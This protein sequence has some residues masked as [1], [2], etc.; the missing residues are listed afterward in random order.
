MIT[1]RATLRPMTTNSGDVARLAANYSTSADAYAELWSPV[2][3]PV[4]RRLLEALLWDRA[5]HVL[6]IG[7]GTGA[8]V[9]DIASLVPGAPVIG[10][11][12]ALGMLALARR[13]G[14]RLAAMDAMHLGFR[15][16]VF[17][18]AVMAFILFHVSDPSAA[19][20][21]VK[22]V[23]RSRGSLGLA[24]WGD[25]PATPATQ[26]WNRE[27]DACAAQDPSPQ[28]DHGDLMNTP[29]KLADLLRAA[30]V[31]PERVWV[32]SVEYQW[33]VARFIGLRTRF[34][35]TKR[36]LE[37]LEPRIREAFLERIADRMSGLDAK[38]FLC[39]GAAICAVAARP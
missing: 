34:G 19:L 5:N 11:D 12:C 9:S 28:P 16:G 27:L 22:R 6:D 23:L 26:V 7:T 33:D 8:L 29:G 10:I 1:T 32:E 30:G 4:G 24:I 37:T 15:A 35:A 17:D 14:V 20:A 36:R 38:D 21:E 2:I 39:R 3:R 25:E 13:D 18:V 31:M